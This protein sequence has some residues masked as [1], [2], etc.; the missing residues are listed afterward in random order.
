MWSGA[1]SVNNPITLSVKQSDSN[2]HIGAYYYVI[3]QSTS[4][5]VDM[6]L[7]LQQKRNVK[8]IQS[9]GFNYKVNY[10]TA[11]ERVKLFYFIAPKARQW[12]RNSILIQSFTK[13]FYPTV[14]VYKNTFANPVT[15]PNATLAYPNLSNYTF[16]M[17]DNFT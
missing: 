3:V 2:F 13:D 16:M 17:G 9:G 11:E 12:F 4:G 7:Q 1:G 15:N 8:Q 5:K 10:Y 14:L 6:Q